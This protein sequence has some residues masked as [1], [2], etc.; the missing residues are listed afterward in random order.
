[1]S[2]V[3]NNCQVSGIGFSVTTSYWEGVFKYEAS[4]FTLFT[5]AHIASICHANGYHIAAYR[6]AWDAH[7]AVGNW[8]NCTDSLNWV[9]KESCMLCNGRLD[10]AARLISGIVDSTIL[11]TMRHTEPI[12]PTSPCLTRLT[13]FADSLCI[14]DNLRLHS[15]RSSLF[16]EFSDKASIHIQHNSVQT[17]RFICP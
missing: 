2:R 3:R 4:E 7:I 10:S 17:Q 15:N 1:M 6:L 14:A 9:D 5:G 11:T 13:I 8:A 16:S 12:T